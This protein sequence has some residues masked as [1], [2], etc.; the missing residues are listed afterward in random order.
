MHEQDWRLLAAPALLLLLIKHRARPP[1]WE[2]AEEEG[3][4]WGAGARRRA[5]GRGKK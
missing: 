4:R 1:G 2:P 5:D 3:R